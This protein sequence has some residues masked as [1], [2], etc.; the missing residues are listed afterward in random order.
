MTRLRPLLIALTLSAVFA[1]NASAIVGGKPVPVGQRGYVAYVSIEPGFACTGTLVTPTHV[2]TA[3]HCS[4]VTGAVAPT[5]VI[6]IAQPPQ[7]IRVTL[8][9][10]KRND[11]AGE[12]RAVSKVT[13][14]PKYVFENGSSYDVAVLELTA[15][16]L[17]TPVKIA[18]VE[19]AGLWA[20]GTLAQIAGFGTT[21]EG[22][23]TP[24]V[25]QEAQVPIVT[26]ATAQN[27][28]PD[29]FEALTQLGAGFPQGGTDTCQGDSGGPLL[30]PAPDGSL[31]LVGDTSYGEGCARANRPGIYGRLA[32]AEL[33]KFVTDQAPGSVAP[34]PRTAPPAQQPAPESSTTTTS[35]PQPAP[36]ST[37]SPAP[38]SNNS[39]TGATAPAKKKSIR[40]KACSAMHRSS[41]KH[42]RTKQ[43][44][45]QVKRCLAQ[46]RAKLTPR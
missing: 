3:G 33:R 31:R 27:A 7:S 36:S 34:A 39:T 20:P 28:Y 17:Q 32:G 25:M 4:A 37:S 40:R 41:R 9:S 6:S 2:V 8:G 15:P 44:K 45:R 24:S 26:D 29:S 35:E 43:H 19:E 46:R 14:H 10:V 5:P 16:S 21:K 23:S 18:A 12:K 11:P 30:V 13:V 38:A 1:P 42:V 22:G